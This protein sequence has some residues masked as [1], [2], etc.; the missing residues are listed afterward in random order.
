MVA[1]LQ[2]QGIISGNPLFARVSPPSNPNGDYDA[3]T[4]SPTAIAVASVS[5]GAFLDIIVASNEGRG[6]VSVLKA[7]P[8]P[9]G[10]T[11]TNYH[12]P[13]SITNPSAINNLTVTV[14]L[15]DQE[16][17]ANLSLVLVAP[18]GVHSITL[19][20]NQNNA[21]GTAIT[22][23]GLPSGNSI[24]V[25]GFGTGATGTFGTSVG[26]VFDDNA[27]RRIF[28]STNT[29]TNGNSA[30]GSGYIGYFRPEVGSLASFVSS[31]GGNLNGTWTLVVT[32]FTSTVAT[33]VAN[34]GELRNL[35]LRFSS[36]MSATRPS[37]I[38]F[39]PVV[40]ALGNTY[41]LKPPASPS[42]G[43]GPGLVLAVDNSL[44]PNSPFAGRIYAAYVDYFSVPTDPNTHANPT[45]N[46]DIVLAYYSPGQGWI[47]ETVVND[48][49]ATSDGFSASGGDNINFAY[50]SGRTQ[51]QPELAVDQS[52]GTL[53]VSWRDARDDAANARVATYLSTSLDGGQTFSARN[54]CQS[55]K[56]RDRRDHRADRHPR[57]ASR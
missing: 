11:P 31:L 40:G 50:T 8:L 3:G 34:Q 24:G 36:G 2:N 53:V 13:V 48:D 49:N 32:N 30:A 23:Q 4:T 9:V 5:G 56:Y 7:S 27:T 22:S 14:D 45:T 33:G 12:V 29:G 37:D 41:P 38:D 25:F 18:D 54:V 15:V 26:T 47:P 39:T 35:N 46:T 20:R 6:F 1:V 17:V 19:V 55:G 10:P 57:P 51:F 21:A 44:G 43:V 52:T 16:S 42:V 28:D